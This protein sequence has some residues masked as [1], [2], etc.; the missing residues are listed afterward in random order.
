MYSSE[1]DR[2]ELEMYANLE[3]TELGEFCRLLCQIE[4]YG[5]MMIT[6]KFSAAV[7]DE[8]KTQLSNFK[9]HTTILTFDEAYTRE[10][11]ELEWH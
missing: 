8:I 1:D 3:G 4:H 6:D 11:K 7:A 10:I 5:S 2:E 9:E